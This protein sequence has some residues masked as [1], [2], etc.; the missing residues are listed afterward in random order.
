MH[1]RTVLNALPAAPLRERLRRALALGPEDRVH[2]L[3]HERF[4]PCR[5]CFGCWIDTPGRCGMRDDANPLMADVMDGEELVWLTRIEHGGWSPLAKAALD[6]TIGL[7]SPFFTT[8]AGETH[9]SPRYARH[10]RWGVVAVLPADVDQRADVVQRERALFLH[11]VQ[12]NALNLH[13][14]DPWVAFVRE[15]DDEQAIHD[16]IKLAR[17]HP[18]PAPTVPRYRDPHLPAGPLPWAP[19]PQR[20]VAWV[21][22]GKPPGESVSEALA[23]SLLDRLAARGWSTELLPGRRMVQ[24]H[25]GRADALVEAVSGADLLI[26]ASPVY[27]D[28]LPAPVLLGLDQLHRAAEPLALLPVLQCG[29]PELSHTALALE[30]IDRVAARWGAPVAGHLAMGGGG[31]LH[32][33]ELAAREGRAWQQSTALDA[34]ADALHAGHRIAPETSAQ[35]SQSVVSPA[36]YRAMGNAGW[37]AQAWKTGAL[38][39]LRAR[40]FAPED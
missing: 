16:A 5:G 39:S 12:R 27:V 3:E 33:A 7:V 20:A 15:D 31:V 4:A 8:L 2:E 40:T 38:W 26:L 17:A 28:S 29:F 35:F 19:G 13:G 25:R 37:L 30:L 10:P 14:A 1:H 11:T 36:V 23:Q 34:A 22:S 24:L 18:L 32:G 6:R 9:H 21:G